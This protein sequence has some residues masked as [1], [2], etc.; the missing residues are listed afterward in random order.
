MPAIG[1]HCHELQI[2]DREHSLRIVYHVADDVIAIL[3]IF[4]KKTQSTPAQVI[5][6]CRKYLAAFMKAAADWEPQ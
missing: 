6:V 4:S 5:T 2:P 1:T 3:E